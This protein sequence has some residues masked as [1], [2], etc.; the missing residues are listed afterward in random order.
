MISL[1]RPIEPNLYFQMRQIRNHSPWLTSALIFVGSV[2]F[3]IEIAKGQDPITNFPLYYSLGGL[4]ATSSPASI[5]S[6]LDWLRTKSNLT[7]AVCG[8]F[9]PSFDIQDMLSNQLNDSLASLAA[10]PQTVTSALPGQILCRAKP[11]MCQLLQH[12]VVRAEKK[13]D[14]SVKSCEDTM[15]AMVDGNDP[16][17]DL[18]E[19]S[20]VQAWQEHATLGSSATVAKRR[21]DNADGCVDWVAGKK[22]GCKGKEPIWLL[23]DTAKTGWCLLLNQNPDCNGTSDSTKDQPYLQRFWPTPESASEWVSDVLGD[24][25]VQAGE[26]SSTVSG[27]GLLPKVD[28][29]TDQ[30]HAKLTEIVYSGVTPTDSEMDQLQSNR[31]ALSPT[32]IVALRDLPDRDFLITRLASEIALAR[33]IEKAFLA[34]RLL[35]S[36]LMEPNIQNSGSVSETIH[37]QI[38]ILEREIERVTFEMQISKRLVSDTVLSVLGAHRTFTTPGPSAPPIREML[39]R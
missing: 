17:Q 4:K 33:I 27:T 38:D 30:L 6:S 28:L 18:M 36:G 26:N 22:S 34:R 14:I 25:R 24:Y 20:R 35:L 16:F 11:G 23:T 9:N 37:K 15:E 7:S 19:I 39:L 21:A 3:C 1:K 10:F 13:W 12:Y 29:E 31:I 5:D 8:G 2:F 32:L